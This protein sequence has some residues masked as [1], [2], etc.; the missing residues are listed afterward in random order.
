MHPIYKKTQVTHTLMKSDMEEK[1]API[2]I[3]LI[4]TLLAVGFGVGLQKHLLEKEQY[5]TQAKQVH[6]VMLDIQTIS[7]RSPVMG[8]SV[9]MGLISDS[10][11]QRLDNQIPANDPRLKQEF[12]SVLQEYN[13]DI[14]VVED[15]TGLVVGYFNNNSAY[16]SLGVNVSY[17]PYWQRAIK[18]I[19]N[20]YPAIGVADELRGLY[21]A[22]PVHRNMSNK[23]PVIGVYTVRVS[24]M[25]LDEKLKIQSS[26]ALLVS[27]D[28][29]VFASNRPEW[30]LKLASPISE[31][32][33]Q[34]LVAEKQFKNLFRDSIPALLPFTLDKDKLTFEGKQYAVSSAALDWLDQQGQW[35]VVLLQDISGWLPLWQAALLAALII[36]MMLIVRWAWL[37]QRQMEAE[38][39]A[40]AEAKQAIQQQA[41]QHLQ[42]LSDALPLAIFQ[43]RSSGDEEHRRYTYASAKTSAILGLSPYEL[44]TNVQ[45]LERIL[46][47]EECNSVVSAITQAF[48][49][50]RDFD[51]EHRILRNGEIC[52][53]RVKAL[54]NRQEEHDWIWNGYWMDITAR[55]QQTEQLRQAKEAA[56][57]ATRTKSMFL[58]NMSHEIRTPMNA[59]IGLAYLA[60]KTELSAKQRDYLNKIHQAGT[61][62]LG[63]INDI[64][65]VSKIEANQLKLEHIA[66]NLDDVL[67][68]L[69]VMSSQRAN[70]KGLELLFDV[71]PDIPRSLL[72][73]PL[74]LGQI[75][76]NLVSNAVKFT[77]QGYVHLQVRQ[78]TREDDQLTLQFTIR[79]TGIGM[80][81]EQ[82]RRLFQAFTQADGSTTRRFGGTGLGLT[83]ARHLVEQMGGTIQVKSEPDI[84]SEFSF[85]IQLTANQIMNEKRR[86]IPGAITGLRILVVD[87][88][89][90]ACDILLAALQQLP[91][92]VEAV[93]SANQAWQRLQ[94]AAQQGVPFHL[95]M[96]DWQM[97]EMNGITLAHHARELPMPP[98]IVLVT[99]FSY[100]DVQQEAKAAGIEGFLTKPI[101]QSQ[102]VDCL[103]HLFAPPQGE[104]MAVLEHMVLPQ[105]RQANVLLAED[106]PINQQIAVEMML[107]SGVHSDLAANGHEAMSLLFSHEPDYYDLVFMDLQMPGLDGHETTLAIRADAR[108]QQL[109]II[110]MTAHALQDERERCLAEGMNDH[111][112]KPI[113]PQLFYK[114]L[115]HYLAHKLS[116]SRQNAPSYSLPLLQLEGLDS[117]TALQRVNGNQTLY[118]QLLQQ[119]CREQ[120]SIPARIRDLLTQQQPT[121]A[122][123]LAHGLKGV[124]ANIGAIKVSE[125]AA[126]LEKALSNSSNIAGLLLMTNQ[127]DSVLQQLC[128]QINT[129]IM[130]H[131]LQL[132]T[133]THHLQRVTDEAL[134]TL[135]KMIG[136]N[137]CGA[138]DLYAQLEP[139][140]QALI[141][142]AELQ[143]INNHLQ[144]F[145]FDLALARLERFTLAAAPAIP[146]AQS[147][148]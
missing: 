100:D 3:W 119:F 83:I 71:P 90:V 118:L 72:G 15:S 20:V 69:S 109:P 31:T 86:L 43:F 27:P 53:V 148:D 80:T 65:D 142:L 82:T 42:D 99:A 87:D 141:P 59:V 114:L 136:D 45:A 18:G 98:R 88:N 33:R 96:T 147:P 127:L 91:L 46:L 126:Q 70:E 44:L 116:G 68:N 107:A 37:L 51:L 133:T 128:D 34:R 14:A 29:V 54:C 145:D 40:A 16:S 135:R 131:D 74:R 9:L 146:D 125:L 52:W 108:F 84:G 35:R 57:S 115:S 144:A 112:A 23:S 85:T 49:E 105:F 1:R 75:L 26:P 129:Q 6:Q 32:Q 124:A 60:L 41:R 22:A 140:L 63:I 48:Q 5:E 138:L 38:T 62:L 12:V 137:D 76:I 143:Q 4:I 89:A 123:P 24:A 122:K 81:P 21:I 110:A 58:A 111:I 101:S 25:L 64:L 134:T 132:T 79:D 13:A 73:D 36:V 113:D 8:A 30:I 102:V 130:P 117:Q 2:L 120:G 50:H 77:E 106:N 61:S 67:A 139:G 55:H 39:V 47:P 103:M 95:L 28:G 97:P 66:F 7:S 56:E 78:Q 17:R 10:I 93:T 19:S 121:I 94:Q 11:K 92:Q 104:T